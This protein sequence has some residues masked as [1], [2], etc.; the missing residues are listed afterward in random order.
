MTK[1]TIFLFFL[2]VVTLAMRLGQLWT[3]LFIL[4]VFLILYA[5]AETIDEH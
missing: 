5:M 1:W 2:I 4:P 3:L